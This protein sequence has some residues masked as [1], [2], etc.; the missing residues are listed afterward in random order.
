MHGTHGDTLSG[1]TVQHRVHDGDIFRAICQVVHVRPAPELHQ[2]LLESQ[3][4][5]LGVALRDH[6]HSVGMQLLDRLLGLV[7]D[8]LLLLAVLAALQHLLLL[9]AAA[10]AV[11]QIEA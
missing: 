11:R 7:E 1:K 8:L 3:A 10:A 9:G 5:G 4:V 2:G 6:L